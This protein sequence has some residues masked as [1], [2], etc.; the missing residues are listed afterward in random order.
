MGMK[1]DATRNRG[2]ELALKATEQV[3]Q[4]LTNITNQK[5]RLVTLKTTVDA[6]VAAV[7]G[8]YSTAD[9]AALLATMQQLKAN[10]QAFAAG[11]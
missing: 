2:I 4:A 11:L 10:V 3:A 5:N 1:E 6:S 8:V 9:K 7:D